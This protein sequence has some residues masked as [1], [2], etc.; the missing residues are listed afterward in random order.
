MSGANASPTG[1]SNQGMT[2]HALSFAV[3]TI[4]GLC[5]VIDRA[6]S[7]LEEDFIWKR[8]LRADACLP[9]KGSPH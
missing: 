2:A 3:I 6:Y 5:A 9:C 7:Y 4:D 8:K 1:R